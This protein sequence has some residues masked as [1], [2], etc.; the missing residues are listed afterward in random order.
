[1]KQKIEGNDLLRNW[2]Y[3]LNNEG[4]YQIYLGGHEVMKIK[5]SYDLMIQV[6]T[7]VNSDLIDA[8]KKGELKLKVGK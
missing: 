6:V 4:Y 1:M 8:Y 2:Q 3:E 5:C 7:K